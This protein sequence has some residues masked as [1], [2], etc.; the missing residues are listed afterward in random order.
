MYK[1]KFMLILVFSLLHKNS[2]YVRFARRVLNFRQRHKIT[3]IS[4]IYIYIFFLIFSHCFFDSI[5]QSFNLSSLMPYK[6]QL[7]HNISDTI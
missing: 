7:N 6:L 4:N 5:Y 3:V 2:I 1:W